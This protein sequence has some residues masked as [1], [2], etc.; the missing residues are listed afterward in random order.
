MPKILDWHTMTE[1]DVAETV[2]I[3]RQSARR[4]DDEND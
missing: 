4:W 1:D 2:R 3:P